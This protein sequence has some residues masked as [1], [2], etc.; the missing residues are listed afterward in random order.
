VNSAGTAFSYST[1]LGGSND[2]TTGGTW[3]EEKPTCAGI[4]VNSNGNA[5]VTDLTASPDFPQVQSLQPFKG[6]GDAFVTEFSVNGTSLVYSTL[7]GGATPDVG[8]GS[9]FS[10]GSALAYLNGNLY[11]A[12]LTNASDFPTSS[13]S[14]GP[15]CFGE[16]W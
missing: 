13:P 1:C 2:E 7:L 16:A 5:Y 12:G 4:A 11:I 14:S 8:N 15:C 9:A 6:V 10:S 3:C